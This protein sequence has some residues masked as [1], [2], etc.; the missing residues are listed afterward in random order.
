[1]QGAASASA[2]G[3]T[4]DDAG[5]ETEVLSTFPEKLLRARSLSLLL[6]DLTLLLSLSHP[7]S[8]AHSL[9]RSHSLSYLESNERYAS[10]LIRPETRRLSRW[11]LS[12][13]V[14]TSPTLT[15]K[16]RRLT[17]ES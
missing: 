2:L 8:T 12:A 13:R 10:R 1:M 16:I 3:Q 9:T 5:T 4:A 15:K 17:Q 7:L 6:L 11:I 14:A